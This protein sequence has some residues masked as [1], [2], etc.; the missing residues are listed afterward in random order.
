ME[1]QEI[2]EDMYIDPTSTINPNYE[3]AYNNKDYTT[4]QLVIDKYPGKG[5]A[6]T[7]N[8]VKMFRLSE[9]YFILAGMCCK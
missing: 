7:K 2:L 9:M 8:D 3:T 6:T 4:D 1:Q 5:S